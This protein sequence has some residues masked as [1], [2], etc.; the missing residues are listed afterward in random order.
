M[1]ELILIRHA[2]PALRGVLLGQADPEL[3]A[4][5]CQQAALL[6]DQVGSYASLVSSPLRR[7]VQTAWAIGDDFR[8]SPGLREWTYGPWDGLSWEQI[9]ARFPEHAAARLNDWFGYTAPGQES[10]SAFTS[11]V[12]S[13]WRELASLPRPLVLVAHEAVNSVLWRIATG[14]PELNFRQRYCEILIA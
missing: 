12:E 3:S 4:A 10:W 11:R 9:E 1:A 14:H 2:E 8:L 6:R 13:A 5:G 7:C